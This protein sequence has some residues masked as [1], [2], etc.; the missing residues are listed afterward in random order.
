MDKKLPFQADAT[1]CLMDDRKRPAKASPVRRPFNKKKNKVPYITEDILGNHVA[2]LTFD[3]GTYDQICLISTQV[4]NFAVGKKN[5]VPHITE[6]ILGH[7][8]ARLTF[9]RGTY[10]QICLIS[11]QVKNFAVGKNVYAPWNETI[12]LPKITR[13]ACCDNDSHRSITVTP[14]QFSPAGHHLVCQLHDYYYQHNRLCFGIMVLF[15][16]DEKD[17]WYCPDISNVVIPFTWSLPN[18]DQVVW[19]FAISEGD[20]PDL[21]VAYG[22]GEVWITTLRKT[23]SETVAGG[24]RLLNAEAMGQKVPKG[25]FISGTEIFTTR[26]SS[27]DTLITVSVGGTL[28]KLD[29][30]D[31]YS[32]V[33]N[34]ISLPPRKVSVSRE[35][36]MVAVLGEDAIMEIWDINTGELHDEIKIGCFGPELHIF[37][38]AITPNGE[39]VLV[40]LSNEK[41]RRRSRIG[42][43]LW[44]YN[45]ITDKTYHTHVWKPWDYLD[46]LF[47]DN[48][49]AWVPSKGATGMYM[50]ENCLHVDTYIICS[51]STFCQTRDKILVAFIHLLN[52]KLR[53]L[54]YTRVRNRYIGDREV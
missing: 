31:N 5:N 52:G 17:Q 54:R 39:C 22:R 50:V 32:V 10:D 47:C 46:K 2:R 42:N 12:E 7:H 16:Q 34:L 26:F 18:I 44:V 23:S 51:T 6:D 28:G 38:I 9:D 20:E 43:F 36:G 14:F 13:Q 11:P 33:Q 24:R 21:I 4:M 19:D 45:R 41:D 29:K 35:S 3:R 25:G 30:S 53:I 37:D 48:K 40:L 15:Q 1:T 49:Y 27:N 8:V